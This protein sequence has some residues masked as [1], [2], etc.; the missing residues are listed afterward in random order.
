L[1]HSGFLK[2]K[3]VR[4]L[5]ALTVMLQLPIAMIAVSKHD[6]GEHGE[7]F[8]RRIVWSIDHWTAH[9]LHELMIADMRHL[10]TFRP[11]SVIPF[12]TCSVPDRRRTRRM[13]AA[14]RSKV[15]G[16]ICSL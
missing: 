11:L 1:A 4:D 6:F 10:L 16:S 14:R 15:L 13:S 5:R 3:A 8:A 7:E 9:A 2:L 12:N